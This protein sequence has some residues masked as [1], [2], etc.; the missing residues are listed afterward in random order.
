MAKQAYTVPLS[1][2]IKEMTLESIHMPCAPEERLV[3]SCDV[4][5]P[6]LA[7]SGYFDYFDFVYM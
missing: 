2:V 3:N 7:L 4:N 6:G 5:R 1:S